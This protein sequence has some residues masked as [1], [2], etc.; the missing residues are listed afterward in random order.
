MRA[1][2]SSRNRAAYER[3]A[4]GGSGWFLFSVRFSNVGESPAPEKIS[5]GQLGGPSGKAKR[6]PKKKVVEFSI[7]LQT[8]S[9]YESSVA[10]SQHHTTPPGRGPQMRRKK[11]QRSA[12]P[13]HRSQHTRPRGTRI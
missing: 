1:F 11:T 9:S 3:R 5:A 8:S 12:G 10:A 6:V 2:D 7:F 13:F 4:L